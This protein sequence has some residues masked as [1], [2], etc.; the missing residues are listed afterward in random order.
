MT[1]V[2]KQLR[3]GRSVNLKKFGAFTF[4]I[5]TEL[6]KIAKR[7]ITA[8]SDMTVERSQRKHVHQLRYLM[9]SVPSASHICLSVVI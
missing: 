4:D 1:Y 8:D 5:Q 9:A 6:P 2:D 7:Q 3:E